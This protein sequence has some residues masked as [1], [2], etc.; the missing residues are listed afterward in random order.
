MGSCALERGAW[1]VKVTEAE[2]SDHQG[3]RALLAPLTLLLPR[4]KLAWGT[5]MLAG[6]VAGL[7]Q[8]TV[9][10]GG[11]NHPRAHGP[12]TRPAGSHRHPPSSPGAG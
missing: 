12:H 8:G 2:P 11:P 6:H 9:G 5:V 7:D 3:D 4:V 10:P 1:A